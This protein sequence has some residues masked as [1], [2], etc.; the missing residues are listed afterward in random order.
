ME[1]KVMLTL[2]SE[3]I[4]QQIPYPMICETRFGSTWD[5]GRRRRAWESQFT[6]QER[7][8]A[9]TL[10]RQ[11]YN[12]HLKKGVPESV[13]MPSQTLLLWNRIAEFCASL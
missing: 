10:F 12:W 9:E 8:E 2:S 4:K 11:A 7:E 3:E 5:T 13:T 6:V 1:A